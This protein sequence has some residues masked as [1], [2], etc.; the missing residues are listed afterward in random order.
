[1]QD[2]KTRDNGLRTVQKEYL[3]NQYWLEYTGND[4]LGSGVGSEHGGYWLGI[5]AATAVN[6][7]RHFSC[8]F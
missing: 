3:Q 6:M 8:S 2:A 7:V 1:M 5:S 4:R